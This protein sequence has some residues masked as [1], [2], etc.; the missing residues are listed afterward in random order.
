MAAAGTRALHFDA[1]AAEALA[2]F[3]RNYEAQE[4]RLNEVRDTVTRFA[5][6]IPAIERN[7]TALSGD[8]RHL[9]EAVANRGR[10]NIPYV[11]AMIAVVALLGPVLWTVVT[12][13]TEGKVSAVSKDIGQLTTQV[14]GIAGQLDRQAAASVVR[15]QK[16]GEIGQVSSANASALTS[17]STQTQRL[18]EMTLSSQSKDATSETDRKQLNDRVHT[19]EEHGA[20]ATADAAA[21][22]AETRARII[23][24]ETQ[25]KGKYDKSNEDK[26]N[27][28]RVNALLWERVFGG[29]FPDVIYYPGPAVVPPLEGVK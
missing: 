16:I 26:A 21:R 14:Q 13:Y 1:D 8:V 19:L 28:H 23:E 27:Q 24:I 7:L 12:G 6:V 25:I 18:T 3:E 5:T 29:R 11:M 10:V 9:T 20:K 2:R 15:D 17:L 22:T 4:R